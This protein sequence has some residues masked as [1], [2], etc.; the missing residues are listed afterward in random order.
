MIF[1]KPFLPQNF[2]IR[3][4]ILSLFSHCDQ[5]NSDSPVGKSRWKVRKCS[6]L[7]WLRTQL[8]I[9][10]KAGTCILT[11]ILTGSVTLSKS[12]LDNILFLPRRG[13][14]GDTCFWVVTTVIK[15][16]N[17]CAAPCSRSHMNAFSVNMIV[18]SNSGEAEVKSR[19]SQVQVLHLL[20]T[21]WTASYC[22]TSCLR[23]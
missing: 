4:G 15:Q 6:I 9:I 20:F 22:S 13:W 23:F 10:T 1:Y 7:W 18:S 19:V 8:C 12:Y 14:F 17:V 3:K 11:L 5:F 21:S 16:E 2:L